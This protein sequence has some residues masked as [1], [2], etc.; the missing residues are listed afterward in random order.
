MNGAEIRRVA[1]LGTGLIGTGWATCFA[2]HDREVTLYDASPERLDLSQK[3]LGTNLAFLHAKGLIDNDTLK[4]AAARVRP[5]G[6]VGEAVQ[7]ADFIQ[8]NV[9]ERLDIKQQLLAEVEAVADPA[10]L[11]ASS[12]S[13]LRITDI[14]AHARYPERCL[15]G[16]PY[17]PP[18]LM[19]LVEL[20]RSART[21]D[22]AI[23]IAHE[24]Y[25]SLGKEPIVLGQEAVGF[26]GNRLQ[27]ALYREA[28]NLVVSG[29]CTVE[30]VDKAC[31]F[32]PGLRW[33][34]MGPNLIFHL[35]G[36]RA[37]IRTVLHHIGPS[38]ERT[39]AELATWTTWPADWPELAQAGVEQEIAHRPPEVGNTLADLAQFRD[40][41]LIELLRRHGKLPLGRR[42]AGGGT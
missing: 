24:F 16:H 23:Q 8:E 20:T 7:D 30:D 33:G 42:N 27:F 6:S 29:V 40:D 3:D 18:H 41:V 22:T 4:Q 11:F 28:V 38:F 1:V 37:G 5:T 31:V 26:V 32:G 35:A 36:G 21:A 13:G 12:T 15:G 10:A 17:N 9:S 25:S 14:T 34:I 39:W 2:L 19:P